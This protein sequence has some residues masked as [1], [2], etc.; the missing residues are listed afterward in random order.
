MCAVKL[1]AFYTPYASIFVAWRQAVKNPLYWYTDRQCWPYSMAT[2]VTWLH[3]L[4]FALRGVVADD[5]HVPPMPT[6]CVT[7]QDCKVLT[8]SG[9]TSQL[10]AG[11]AS[12]NNDLG[13]LESWALAPGFLEI[14]VFWY[15]C[16]LNCLHC[17][18]Q[19]RSRCVEVKVRHF[20]DSIIVWFISIKITIYLWLN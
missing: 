4:H 1:Q 7:V 12:A 18:R 6:P 16:R 14:T 3:L 17:F 10:M 15:F 8:G 9:H 13:L 2:N 11:T 20:S 5:M 19:K